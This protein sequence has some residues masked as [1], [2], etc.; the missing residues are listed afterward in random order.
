MP[1]RHILRLHVLLTAILAGPAIQAA[2][3]PPK[4][5][6][7]VELVS[8]IPSKPPANRFVLKLTLRNAAD[9]PRWFVVPYFGNDRLKSDT[10]RF[11]PR[12]PAT[13]LSGR[14]VTGAVAVMPSSSA[15]T[16]R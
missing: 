12:P 4:P 7:E 15:A 2:Y 3:D 11:Y 6:C 13:R 16:G 9:E 14:A 5:G 8:R 1:G 10:I